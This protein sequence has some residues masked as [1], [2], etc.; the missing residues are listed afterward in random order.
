MIP[1]KYF[2]ITFSG[3][4]GHSKISMEAPIPPDRHIVRLIAAEQMKCPEKN[5]IIL[6]CREVTEDEYNEFTL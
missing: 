3:P 2:I 5:I 6:S 1:T 4:K